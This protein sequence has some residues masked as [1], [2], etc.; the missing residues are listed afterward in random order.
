MQSL[1]NNTTF[2]QFLFDFLRN[3]ACTNIV[4]RRAMQHLTCL[5]LRFHMGMLL[6]YM[7]R[8]NNITNFF[9]DISVNIFLCFCNGLIYDFVLRYDENYINISDYFIKNYDIENYIKWKR[10]LTL[11]ICAYLIVGLSIINVDNKIFLISILQYAISF[12]VWESIEKKIFQNYIKKKMEKRRLSRVSKVVT[13][14]DTEIVKNFLKKD[15]ETKIEEPKPQINVMNDNENIFSN[16][17]F[18]DYIDLKYIIN[19]NFL[20]RKKY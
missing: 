4:L 15:Q 20:E 6:S 11:T 16:E 9:V 14:T 3:S 13:F 17:I 8:Y 7:L 18:D 5:V 1:I 19:K 2:N 10:Y 12:L